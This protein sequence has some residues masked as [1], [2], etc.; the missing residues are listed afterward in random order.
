MCDDTGVFTIS[1][2]TEI[3]WEIF[4]KGDVE[5]YKEAYRNTPEVI[6]RLCDIFDEYEIPAMWAIVSHLLEECNWDHSDRISLGFE[7]IDD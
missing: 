4:N 7:W 5:R 1:L 2:D 3:A 6:D